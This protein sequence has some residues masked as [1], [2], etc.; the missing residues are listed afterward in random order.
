[1][2]LYFHDYR[3]KTEDLLE[4]VLRGLEQEPKRLHPKFF[5]DE[6]G[7]KI[8]EVICEQPEYYLPRVEQRIYADNA[9]EIAARLG[10][11]RPLI[12]PGAG[13]GVKVRFLLDRMEPSL[14][15]P[16]DISAAHLKAS[17]ARLAHDYPNIPIHAV[18]VD[19]TGEY[20]LPDEIP[21]KERIFFYPGSSLGNFSPAEALH[22]LSDLRDKAGDDGL[23]LIGID[24]KKDSDVL[25]RAYNDAAGAT[26]AFNL[27]LLERI[28]N[29]LDTDLD[30]VRFEHHAF[31]NPELGRVE[32]HLRCVRDHALRVNGQS[33][34]FES[35]E[36]IHTESSYKYS[37]DEFLILAKAAGWKG[38]ALWQDADGQFSVHLLRSD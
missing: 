25:D 21:T 27:N 11:H 28:R 19:H 1:M 15:A 6:A 23:L 8:F 38:E 22:F 7:S 17:A 14:Y 26:A 10:R 35:G 18:C 12:E 34:H 36:T 24:T 4:A 33:F 13:S 16:M 32:M 20:E 30:P 31:Y 5:Y 3:P 2:S 9:E 37:P 29:Q